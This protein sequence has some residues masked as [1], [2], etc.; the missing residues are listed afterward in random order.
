M[1]TRQGEYIDYPMIYA[2]QKI[3]LGSP[4]PNQYAYVNW[5][6]W[7]SW[8]LGTE[9]DSRMGGTEQPLSDSK[10][11]QPYAGASISLRLDMGG[12]SFFSFIVIPRYFYYEL[13]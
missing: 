6:L 7:L 1:E 3:Y 8:Y 2:N 13:W 5:I 9:D 11:S 10:S 4:C 12:C